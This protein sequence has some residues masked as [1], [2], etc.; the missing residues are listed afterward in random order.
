MNKEIKQILQK[1]SGIPKPY[2]KFRLHDLEP[3]KTIIQWY[4]NFTTKEFQSSLLLYCADV[5]RRI[6]GKRIAI[7]LLLE[8]A[9]NQKIIPPA[10]YLTKTKF[11][12]YWRQ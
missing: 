2:W 8:L 7:S 5:N 1:H 10:Y 9:N 3:N 6:K 12:E 11:V 4:E